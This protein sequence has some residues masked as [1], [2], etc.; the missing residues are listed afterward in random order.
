MTTNNTITIPKKVRILLDLKPGD[1]LEYEVVSNGSFILA[2]KECCDSQL[3]R[4]TCKLP[5]QEKK[6]I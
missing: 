4:P 3:L 5:C 1:Y 6:N 2:R